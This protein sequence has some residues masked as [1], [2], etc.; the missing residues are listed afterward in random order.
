MLET[1][2]RMDTWQLVLPPSRP[3]T[4]QLR[5]LRDVACNVR[6]DAPVAVLGSTPEYRDLLHE[7]GF[8]SIFIFE[9]NSTFYAQ[10]SAARIFDNEETLIEGDWCITLAQHRS[11]FHLILSDLTSGNLPYNRHPRFYDDIVAALAD[12]GIFFDKVLTH[13]SEFIPLS[14]LLATYDR[15]PLNLASANRFSCEVLFCSSLLDGET[16]IVDSTRFYRSILAASQSPRI[17]A[18]VESSKLITPEGCIWYYGR[19]WHALSQT[20]CR[21]LTRIIDELDEP[22][23]PYFGRLRFFASRRGPTE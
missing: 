13:S 14:D 9:K 1:W 18:F 8:Q 19:P 10:M 11:R 17:R 15:T 6:R 4:G 3:S 22:H 20:Y 7:E 21:G 12:G 16:G 5:L 2:E 23:S